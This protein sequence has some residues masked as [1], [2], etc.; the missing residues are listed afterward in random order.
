MEITIKDD[1]DKI[2]MTDESLSNDNYVELS[3]STKSSNDFECTLNVTI[4]IDE[5]YIAAQSFINK[6]EIRLKKE[7]L[8]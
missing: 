7:K 4:N 2:I 8:Y 6:R 1:T 3:I 5:L